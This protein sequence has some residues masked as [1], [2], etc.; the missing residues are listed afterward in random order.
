MPKYNTVQFHMCKIVFP[1][2]LLIYLYVV[3]FQYNKTE[4][5]AIGTYHFTMPN[6]SMEPIQLCKNFYEQG[7]IWAFNESYIFDSTQDT[8]TL[9]LLCTETKYFDLI[10]CDIK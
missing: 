8:G 9:L 10:I 5:I 7:V 1:L 4:T 3:L 2:P 6:N